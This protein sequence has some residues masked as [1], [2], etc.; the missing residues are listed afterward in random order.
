MG[1]GIG[2][3]VCVRRVSFDGWRGWGSVSGGGVVGDG[4]EVGGGRF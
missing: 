4:G 1:R 2:G 3:T